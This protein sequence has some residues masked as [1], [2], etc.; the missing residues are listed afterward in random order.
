MAKAESLRAIKIED[1]VKESQSNL[2]IDGPNW[3]KMLIENK[4]SK[5]IIKLL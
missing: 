1:V 3:F 5:F 2:A 4:C